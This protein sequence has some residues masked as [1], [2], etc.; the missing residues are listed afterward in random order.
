MA[1]AREHRT[2]NLDR[3]EYAISQGEIRFFLME[4]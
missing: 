4:S 2:A 1:K 3:R